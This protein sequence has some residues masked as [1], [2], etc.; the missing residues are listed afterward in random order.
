[1]AIDDGNLMRSVLE[2]F[3]YKTMKRY[4]HSE[5]KYIKKCFKS[6]IMKLVGRFEVN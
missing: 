6:D 4:F 2:C 1:M 3:V 5:K